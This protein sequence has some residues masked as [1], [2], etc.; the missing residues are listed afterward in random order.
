[1]T[2][3]K[4]RTT[5]TPSDQRNNNDSANNKHQLEIKKEKI[6]AKGSEID[7]HHGREEK[8][9]T[10]ADDTSELENAD[11]STVTTNQG[12]KLIH[13]VDGREDKN[14]E[15]II[16]INEQHF[17]TVEIKKEN[18]AHFINIFFKIREEP[19]DNIR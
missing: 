6:E 12:G 15:G 14:Q 8:K 16:L 10:N 2:D 19:S 13:N 17:K 5:A 1:M 18:Y 3:K 11:G 9:K 7:G 4:Q